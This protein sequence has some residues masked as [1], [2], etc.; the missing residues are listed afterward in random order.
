M[1]KEE[2]AKGERLG[3]LPAC[4]M[5][6]RSAAQQPCF[7]DGQGLGQSVTWQGSLPEKLEWLSAW[8]LQRS[9]SV[10]RWAAVGIINGT[11]NPLQTLQAARRHARGH[12]AQVLPPAA[13]PWVPGITEKMKQNPPPPPRGGEGRAFLLILPPNCALRHKAMTHG[14]YKVLCA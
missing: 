12:R 1:L 10:G 14:C 13:E 6:T 4:T 11:A 7:C 5:C 9:P 8:G 3:A 2:P